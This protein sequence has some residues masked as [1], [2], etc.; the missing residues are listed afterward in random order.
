MTLTQCFTAGDARDP[1]R[2]IGPLA[3]PGATGCD[4]TE[5]SYSGGTFRFALDCSGTYGL[6]ARGSVS[7]AAT[8]F[9]GAMSATGNVGGQAVDLENRV[10]GRRLGDC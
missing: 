4:F 7:F 1:S 5:R 10:S 9:E 8:S 6:K 2:I 3:T